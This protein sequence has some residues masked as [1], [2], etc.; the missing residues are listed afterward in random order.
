MHIV[1]HIRASASLGGKCPYL[2]VSICSFDILGMLV[3]SLGLKLASLATIGVVKLFL[4]FELFL[5][6]IVQY[7]TN[8]SHVFGQVGHQDTESDCF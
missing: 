5:D 3:Y 8:Q 1:S 2:F 6:D 7:G 4:L